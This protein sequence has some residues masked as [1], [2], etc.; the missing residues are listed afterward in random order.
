[1]DMNNEIDRIIKELGILR[2]NIASMAA[3]VEDLQQALENL[4]SCPANEPEPVVLPEEPAAPEVD[5][6]VEPADISET[7]SVPSASCESVADDEAIAESAEM[8]E[9][10][11]S[12]EEP[13]S[14]EVPEIPEES[15]AS[16][17]P[18]D[19]VSESEPEP[20]CEPLPEQQPENDEVG[21]TDDADDE[22]EPSAPTRELRQFLTI[23]DRYRFR[24]ELFGN[25]DTAM[26]DTLNM[27]EAMGSLSEAQEYLYSD[28]EWDPET[29]EVKEFMVIIDR[30]FNER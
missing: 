20:E 14:D 6:A 24:R 22:P 12:L 23:N 17:M 11:E 18:E 27:I 29:E 13:E 10:E 8:E 5:A 1:M 21:D 4:K 3:R 15:V 26:A 16:D 7:E 25:S 2:I 30:Y 19:S 9:E 28:L